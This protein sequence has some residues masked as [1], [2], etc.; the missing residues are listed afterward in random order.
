MNRLSIYSSRYNMFVYRTH[1][2]DESISTQIIILCIFSLLLF[3]QYTSNCYAYIRICINKRKK[4]GSNF[5]LKCFVKEQSVK[6]VHYYCKA[7]KRE[8]KSTHIY[9]Y[10]VGSTQIAKTWNLYFIDRFPRSF[11]CIFIFFLSWS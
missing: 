11:P 9:V 10:M 5:S 3:S 8:F 1:S 6:R 7:K 4:M 2:T